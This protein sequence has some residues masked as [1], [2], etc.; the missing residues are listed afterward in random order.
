MTQYLDYRFEEIEL[1][2]GLLADGVA[3]VEYSVQ[4]ACR[5]VGFGGEVDFRVTEFTVE[6]RDEDDNITHATLKDGDALY[7]ELLTRLE[8]SIINECW[9]VSHGSF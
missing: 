2:N 3:A 6:M 9:D 4:G 1:S 7:T 8:R 5:S